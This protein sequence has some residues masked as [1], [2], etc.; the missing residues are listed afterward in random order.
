VIGDAQWASW[1]DGLV[2]AV[3]RWSA[4]YPSNPALP[5]AAAVRDLELPDAGLLE[6]LV[7]ARPELHA[8][9]EGVRR[10]DARVTFAP[11]IQAALDEVRATLVADPFKAPEVADLQAAGLDEKT[12]AGAVRAGLLIRIATGVYLGPDALPD[13]LQRLAGLA[14]PFTVSDARQALATTRRVALPLLE[15]LDRKGFTRRV[16]ADHRMVRPP[17]D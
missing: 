2:A 7:A 5:R 15:Q 4:L 3:D 10:V 16:D 17:R 1:T 9:A 8:A 6:L 14:Q 13:A 11:S 12:L